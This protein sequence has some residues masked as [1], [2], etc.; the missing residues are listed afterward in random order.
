MIENKFETVSGL[1]DNN[2]Q[3][4]E[5]LESVVNEQDLAQR[6]ENYHLI[7]DVLRDDVPQAIQLDLSEQIAQAIADEPT[8]LAPKRSNLLNSVKGKVVQ[9]AKP[10]GQVAIAASA[11]GLMILGVQ[12]SNVAD[13]DSVIPSQQIVQT[14]P[15][16]GVADP[17]SLNYQTP[18]RAA[19]Q[20]AYIEQQRRFQ[21]LLADHNQQVKLSS[22]AK[23]D[24]D[25]QVPTN[26]N[27][28]T[29]EKAEDKF[30]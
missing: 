28:A 21:A 6:W 10:F 12:T 22:V 14:V 16:A 17:V 20:Q 19:Q 5:K 27:D 13:N 30:K 29:T 1:M 11:A 2:P 23:T 25:S 3:D 9:F 18:S 7:G 8:V 4:V 26:E 24:V 15:F